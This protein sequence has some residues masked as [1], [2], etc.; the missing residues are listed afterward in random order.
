M[1]VMT[2]L[3]VTSCSSTPDP[4]VYVGKTLDVAYKGLGSTNVIDLTANVTGESP[5]Q[6]PAGPEGWYIVA[7][8]VRSDPPHYVD[9]G[10]IPTSLTTP[11]IRA[12]A[13]KGAYDKYVF[14][15]PAATPSAQ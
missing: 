1:V 15:C 8:C 13:V 14:S 3:L 6:N 4:K 2:A 11:E 12:Q 7:A 9:L 5:S 10:V